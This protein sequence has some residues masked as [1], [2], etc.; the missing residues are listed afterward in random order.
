LSTMNANKIF[1]KMKGFL[2][3]PKAFHH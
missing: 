2:Y 3:N 1:C